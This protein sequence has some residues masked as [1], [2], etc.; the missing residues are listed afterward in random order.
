M[1]RQVFQAKT[2]VPARLRSQLDCSPTH[3]HFVSQPQSSSRSHSSQPRPPLPPQDHIQATPS[4]MKNT[5]KAKPTLPVLPRFSRSHSHSNTMW[6]WTSQDELLNAVHALS[7]DPQESQ[8]FNF[9]NMDPAI[10]ILKSRFLALLRPQPL[11]NQPHK[12][13]NSAIHPVPTLVMRVLAMFAS[14]LE[15]N[16]LAEVNYWIMRAEQDCYFWKPTIYIKHLLQHRMPFLQSRW[17]WRIWFG[18]GITFSKVESL[19]ID[20]SLQSKW[21]PWCVY[22]SCS[23]AWTLLIP[24]DSL[25]DYVSGVV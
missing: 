7:T 3:S 4:V 11:P 17:A 22:I 12:C 19:L 20:T 2:L 9:Y 25:L 16:P 6:P 5:V 18:S 10:W 21:L 14:S 24:F 15:G 23:P 1:S 8:D 13:R